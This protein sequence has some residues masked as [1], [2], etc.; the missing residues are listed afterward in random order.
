MKKTNITKG[1]IAT[2]ALFFINLSILAGNPADNLIHNTEEVNGLV[3]SETVY[4]M[5]D[6]MLNNYMKHNYKYDENNQKIEDE[7]LK[8]NSANKEWSKELCIRYTYS[9]KSYT[10]KYYKWNNKKNEYII[11]PEMT[12]TIDK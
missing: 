9:G 4:K 8:W 12:I 11:V 6:N 2:A 7:T 5:S 10:A 1:I 3:I